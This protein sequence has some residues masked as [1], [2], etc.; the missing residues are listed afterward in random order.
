MGLHFYVKFGE[1]AQYTDITEYIKYD[2][3]KFDIQ[4]MS[5]SF[6]SVQDSVSAKTVYDQ[7][8]NNKFFT[9]STWMPAYITYDLQEEQMYGYPTDN[10]YGD[11]EDAYGFLSPGRIFTGA[12]FPN[13]KEKLQ[14][15]PDEGVSFE[16]VDNGY[17]LEK[18]NQY[19]A[20]PETISDTWYVFNSSN[21]AR[22]FIHQL[23]YQGGILDEM[24]EQDT[25]ITNELGPIIIEANESSLYDLI[26][27][28]LYEYHH[29]FY[30][31]ENGI[32]RLYDWKH[33][34]ITITD[35]IT[36]SDVFDAEGIQR[37][38]NILDYDGYKT[39]FKPI[40]LKE[41]ALVYR[42]D[43]GDDGKLLIAGQAYPADGETKDVLQ[44]FATDWISEDADIVACYNHELEYTADGTLTI[45]KQEFNNQNAQIVLKNNTGAN[46][47]LNQFDIRA[48]VYF[49]D[50]EEEEIVPANLTKSEP[51]DITYIHTSIDAHNF[52][53]ALYNN[54]I[55]YG[56]Y[57]YTFTST[58]KYALN[59]SYTIDNRDYAVNVL[60]IGKS[61]DYYTKKIKYTCIGVG[62]HV[63]QIGAG[64]YMSPS[65]NPSY[66]ALNKTSAYFAILNN[67]AEFPTSISPTSNGHI[68]IHGF[69]LDN[70]AK[71]ID[72]KIKYPN[73]EDFFVTIP[74]QSVDLT[75]SVFQNVEID[76]DFWTYL[77]LDNGIITPVWYSISDAIFYDQYNNEITTGIIIGQVKV[78]TIPSAH[79][80]SII[81]ESEPFDIARELTTIVRAQTAQAFKYLSQATSATEFEQ[82]AQ[83]L[84]ITDFFT[85]LA[86]W[87]LFAEKL[88]VNQLQV[89]HGTEA[90]G[91]VFYAIDDSVSGQQIIQAWADG[92][93]IFEIDPTTKNITIGDYENENGIRWVHADGELIFKG[94]GN[95]TGEI[96]HDA[97]ATRPEDNSGS[98]IATPSK[99]RYIGSTLYSVLSSVSTS[100]F[101]NASGT[102][103]GVAISAL[104]RLSTD[105]TLREVWYHSFTSNYSFN[106][107]ITARVKITYNCISTFL[108]KNKTT[109]YINGNYASSLSADI[110]GESNTRSFYFNITKGSSI[111]VVSDRYP[112]TQYIRME[113]YGKGTIVK[114]SAT[115]MEFLNYYG[116]YGTQLNIS[117]PNT[118]NYASYKYYASGLD[119]MSN[120]SSLTLNKIYNTDITQSSM[121]LDGVPKTISGVLRT[122]SEMKIY[123]TDAK[124]HVVVGNNTEGATT[125]WYNM[126]GSFKLLVATPAILTKFI[127]PKANATY[128]LGYKDA[129]NSANDKRFANLYLSNNIEGKDTG[130]ISGFNVSAGTI[131]ASST[132]TA[133]SSLIIAGA[134]SPRTDP[135]TGSQSVAEGSYYTPSRGLYNSSW[136]YSNR[137]S[138]VAN[139]YQDSEPYNTIDFSPGGD[140]PYSGTS[141]T[142]IYNVS[143]AF[144][145]GSTMT[146]YYAKF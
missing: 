83:N 50:G 82:Y 21:T 138:V 37:E 69:S 105:T 124:V 25:I 110:W 96:E 43:L 57:I 137:G 129:S 31:D 14:D 30:F 77:V 103:N 120:A 6:K 86:V 74:K 29:V 12:V 114:K 101:T 44:K 99:T 106:S 140:G 116:Y 107:P 104:S 81:W 131:Y 24:I 63:G 143:V 142:R 51:L 109:I 2:S 119:Y 122:S 145:N 19:I 23:L 7:T 39:V 22:S 8:I 60:I 102:Y 75:A 38:K 61:Y 27:D 53:E 49:E 72:G 48:D 118:F 62:S 127:E 128:D 35:T 68:Y 9:A 67:I 98:T 91:F 18:D 40:T 133:N 88:K 111:S 121:T 17:L 92:I 84:G 11:E 78:G 146:W 139:V 95:F 34:T 15:Y 5:K 45:V 10:V 94:T 71:D 117:A 16:I 126:S 89:G 136:S 65:S 13:T 26:Q 76:R 70:T 41:N 144:Y 55:K 134:L 80:D 28:I 97:L 54:T 46:I 58:N 113:V 1:D 36:E 52:A 112:Q 85:T 47:R 42:A 141:T 135:I 64:S 115:D 73:Q 100:G 123:F 79:T 32:F 132:L 125:G 93:K 59:N 3:V 66:V 130:T 56:Q 20:I 87:E 4:L 33:D 108:S 90:E